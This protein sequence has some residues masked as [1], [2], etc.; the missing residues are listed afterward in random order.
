MQAGFSPAL[1][2]SCPAR[3]TV[4]SYQQPT[5]TGENIMGQYLETAK[6]LAKRKQAQK[7]KARAINNELIEVR[8]VEGMGRG[9]FAR[10]NFARGDLVC[11]YR[12]VLASYDDAVA[13]S[14]TIDYSINYKDQVLVP[15][16]DSVGGHLINHSCNPNTRWDEPANGMIGISACKKITVGEQ[17]TIFYGWFGNP[18]SHAALKCLCGSPNCFG[19]MGIVIPHH[20]TFDTFREVAKKHL[21]WMYESKSEEP[22]DGFIGFCDEMASLAGIDFAELARDVV[23]ATFQPFSAEYDWLVSIFKKRG[24]VAPGGAKNVKFLKKPVKKVAA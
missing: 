1:A 17:I 21:R 11:T 16:I 8:T 13:R 9:V 6:Q 10:R 7:Q 12:G 20:F 5:E 22:V 15:D 24:M 18:D 23:L 14:G 4:L 19:T 3:G 2:G